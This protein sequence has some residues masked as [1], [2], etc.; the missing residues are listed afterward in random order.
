MRVLPCIHRPAIVLLAS[1]AAVAV[2]ATLVS[3]C[4]AGTATTVTVHGA[5]GPVE[6]RVELA[7]TRETQARGLMWR[8]KLDRGTGMLFVFAREHERAFW[9]KNT[10]V[11]LDII[12]IDSSG[13]VVS[14]AENTTPYSTASIPSR[15]PAKYVL[16]V[17]AGFA[18]THGVGPGSRVDIPELPPAPPAGS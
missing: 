1:A 7:H 16:E 6:V 14:V 4:R 17:N 18:S 15:A 3:G 10:P 11:P 9:M 2:P 8:E 12:Y 5:N 13:G